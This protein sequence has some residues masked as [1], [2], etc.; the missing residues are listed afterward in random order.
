MADAKHPSVHKELRELVTFSG[1]VDAVY[2][3]AKGPVRLDNGKGAW[4]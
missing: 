2:R 3:G 1:P 4:A